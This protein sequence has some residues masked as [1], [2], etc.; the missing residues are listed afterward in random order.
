MYIGPILILHQL[1]KG[2]KY[3]QI[4]VSVET[5]KQYPADRDDNVFLLVLF[6]YL[7]DF[8]I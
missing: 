8:I 3:P 6:V 2:S 1:E 4:L 7:H 5:C